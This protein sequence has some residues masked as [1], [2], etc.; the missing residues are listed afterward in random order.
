MLDESTIV[1]KCANSVKPS[2]AGGSAAMAVSSISRHAADT[3]EARCLVCKKLMARHGRRGA[4][5]LQQPSEQ[6]VPS[7]AKV[8]AGT[9]NES[10]DIRQIGL[11]DII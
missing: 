9:V 10:K 4:N 2:K 7:G 11:S 6:I 5:V 3:T 8:G 1:A